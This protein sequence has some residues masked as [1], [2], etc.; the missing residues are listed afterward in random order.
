MLAAILKMVPCLAAYLNSIFVVG[1]S[2]DL[3]NNELAGA[4]N[5]AG[6]VSEIG[7]LEQNAVI[8]FM[9]TDGVFDMPDVAVSGGKFC[10]QV[11]NIT[12]AI[13]TESEAVGH[14]SGAILSQ[15]KGMLP[16]M[17][18][19]RVATIGNLS[20][21]M[22]SQMSTTSLNLLRHDHLHQ[23][24]AIEDGANIPSVIVS[25]VTQNNAF[26]VIESNMKFP[27]LPF[28]LSAFQLERRTLGLGNFQRLQVCTITTLGIDIGWIIVYSGLSPQRA[29]RLGDVNVDNLVLVTVVDG[30]KVQ[31]IL[32]LAVVDVRSE[33]HQRLLEPH[34]AAKSLVV[35]NRPR[36]AINLV[37][38]ISRNPTKFALLNH[39]WI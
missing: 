32:I 12:L 18:A 6:F 11:A 2:K 30:A 39:I 35:A 9:N 26:S 37:H 29:S 8:F 34:V 3:L 33:V 27:I 17:R 14:V 5:D 1:G 7:V 24:H 4:G 16:L 25:D 31:R 38:L 15:I 22:I 36:I 20:D 23:G 13:A 28:N 19:L 10:I 21:A